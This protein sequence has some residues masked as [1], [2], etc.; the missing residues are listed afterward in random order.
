MTNPGCGCCCRVQNVGGMESRPEPALNLCCGGGKGPETNQTTA[1]A[2]FSGDDMGQTNQTTAAMKADTHYRACR[3]GAIRLRISYLTR[4]IHS[5]AL[6]IA[7]SI[8]QSHFV[9]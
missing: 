8:F 1:A 7:I 4:V 5:S 2:S 3:G 6:V 9:V